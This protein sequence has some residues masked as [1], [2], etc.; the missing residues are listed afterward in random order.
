MPRYARDLTLAVAVFG[1]AAFIAVGAVSGHRADPGSHP[2]LIASAPVF[3]LNSVSVRYVA[4]Q[5]LVAVG[6]GADDQFTVSLQVA[7]AAAPP[8]APTPPPTPPPARLAPAPRLVV[9][10]PTPA[11]A[12]ASA[13]A[14]SSGG[15]VQSLIRQ[16]FGPLG[17]TAVNWGLRVAACESGYNPA[18]Y[19]PAGPYY[20]VFQFALATFRATPYGGSSPF[21]AAA[22]VAAAAWKYAR[23]GASAWGCN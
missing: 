15:S 16:D 17:A 18:A 7:E 12:P 5:Q 8:P 21:D 1:A 6:A 23:G 11:P 14:P 9:R 13:P 10:P 22:N 19:N 20:G 3:E 2:S 4:H